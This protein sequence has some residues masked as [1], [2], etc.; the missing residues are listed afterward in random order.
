MFSHAQS[1]HPNRWDIT[2]IVSLTILSPSD[3]QML[4]GRCTAQTASHWTWNKPCRV[5]KVVLDLSFGSN[6]TCQYPAFR[7]SNMFSTKILITERRPVGRNFQRGVRRHA[8]QVA[9]LS[10]GGLGALSDPQKSRGI[11]SKILQSSNFK[12]LHSNFRKVLFFKILILHQLGLWSVTKC[13]L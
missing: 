3:I 13:R 2:A 6:S 5:A 4:P 8:S 12:A 1:H 7:S 9:H 10:A 11:W